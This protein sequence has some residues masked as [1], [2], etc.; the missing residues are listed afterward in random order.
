MTATPDAGFNFAGWNNLDVDETGRL[1]FIYQN[2][3]YGFDRV[4]WCVYLTPPSRSGL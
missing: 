3:Y 2:N 1:T 4:V